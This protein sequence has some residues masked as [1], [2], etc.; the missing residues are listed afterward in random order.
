MDV[1]G[2][3]QRDGTIAFRQ[4]L[5][6]GQ[7]P[8]AI[9]FDL[10]YD[11][12][13]PI[14]AVR[15]ATDGNLEVRFLVGPR[16]GTGRPGQTARLQD[17]DLDLDDS[18]EPEVRQRIA[19]Y[20][21]VRS[22]CGLLATE[23]S[24]RTAVHRRWGLPGGGIDRHE[25]PSDAVLRE[26]AEET[27]QTIRLGELVE[28]QSA[29]WIGRNP[30]DTIEDYHAVRLVY[31]AVCDHP[32]EPVV[33][34]VGGTTE[35]ARWVKLAEWRQLPWTIGWRQVLTRLVDGDGRDA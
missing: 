15:R 30:R 31:Q 21:L 16:T 13:R 32:T 11:A 20:A 14:E 5:P 4:P 1:V 34:D 26:V 23:F 17:A 22:T 35:S 29:H 2:V 27:Q 24:N 19:A 9:A 25:Q 10:G 28:V 6:H 3:D 12:I 18:I 33:A 7:D 8:A